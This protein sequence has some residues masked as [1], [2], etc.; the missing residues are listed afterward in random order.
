VAHFE[1][2]LAV[3]LALGYANA[4]RFEAEGVLVAWPS[5]ARL[6]AETGSTDAGVR[7]SVR[8]LRAAGWL[9]IDL[10]GGGRAKTTHFKLT[11]PSRLALVPPDYRSDKPGFS[12]PGF[13][14]KPGQIE[15]ETPSDRFAKPGPDAP[16]T[17]LREHLEDLGR[18]RTAFVERAE[19]AQT[20][21]SSGS[22]PV[23]PPALFAEIR[24]AT[25][26]D[27]YRVCDVYLRSC[28]WDAPARTLHPSSLTARLAIER[29]LRPQLKDFS[30][31]VGAPIPGAR[32]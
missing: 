21:G 2:R 1:A 28:L 3:L 7:R 30:L 19:A 15:S 32:L 23:I 14:S 29:D 8:A 27:P 9:D 31:I 24:S 6:A 10:A 13:G 26:D 12:G 22:L 18:A 4:D 16:P 11:V 20:S 5:K 17:L 25:G